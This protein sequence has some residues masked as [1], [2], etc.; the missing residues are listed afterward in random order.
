MTRPVSFRPAVDGDA[1]GID[2]LLGFVT[3]R[4]VDAAAW[5]FRPDDP[6]RIM[7]ADHDGM[8]VGAAWR[9]TNGL[10]PARAR[11]AL[12]V[13]PDWR[14][15]GIAFRLWD[16]LRAQTD[17]P[18][19]WQCQVDGRNLA[20][21]Q[22][23]SRFGFQPLMRTRIG[24]V[25]PIDPLSDAPPDLPDGWRLVPLTGASVVLR[26]RR[27]LARL[28]ADVYRRQHGWDPPRPIDDDEAR[29]LFVDNPDDPLDDEWSVLA[30]RGDRPVG[31]ASLRRT[32]VETVAG[33]HARGL[34]W[35][36]SLGAASGDDDRICAALTGWCLRRAGASG[37]AVEVELDD[38]HAAAIRY[39]EG[40]GVVWAREWLTFAT[41]DAHRRTGHPSVS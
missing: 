25:P 31:I 12:G 8:I 22:A 6:G 1:A 17:A 35:V 34:G 2:A 29:R 26:D 28:H 40:A 16:R 20:G 10:H 3:A 13:H 15:R 41:L 36:G 11:L 32:T 5:G 30:L 38:T 19:G 37:L 23:L 14:R 24:L 39:C 4:D 21:R 27:L 18:G 33:Q 7:V 9:W